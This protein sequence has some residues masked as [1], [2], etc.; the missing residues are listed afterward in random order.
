MLQ[1]HVGPLYSAPI[2]AEATPL[3]T[4]QTK[5]SKSVAIATDP[6]KPGLATAQPERKK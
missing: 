4:A 3:K 6:T 5:V 1:E 2:A